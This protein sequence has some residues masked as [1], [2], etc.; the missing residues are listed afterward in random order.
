[1]SSFEPC[2]SAL[3]DGNAKTFL[4]FQVCE[5]VH[6][7]ILQDRQSLASLQSLNPIRSIDGCNGAANGSALKQRGVFA[8]AVVNLSLEL[9]E[10]DGLEYGEHGCSLSN[11]PQDRCA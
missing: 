5:Q 4:T 10:G 1:M 7:E 3:P 6:E 2:L 11:T 9:K 8:L